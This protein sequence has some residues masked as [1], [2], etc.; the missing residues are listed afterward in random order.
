MDKS[1]K[2]KIKDQ[3]NDE[4]YLPDKHFIE[5]TRKV[6][7]NQIEL[8]KS[9]VKP[10]KNNIF[11]NKWDQL[12][13]FARS[14]SAVPMYFV[15]GILI[16]TFIA[17]AGFGGFIR[18]PGKDNNP[19][20]E[21]PK[22]EIGNYQIAALDFDKNGV[23]LDSDLLLKSDKEIDPQVLAQSIKISPELKFEVVKENSSDYKIKFN[24]EKKPNTLYKLEIS[25]YKSEDN[26][27]QT[28]SFSWA[29]QTVNQFRVTNSLPGKNASNV[30]VNTGI[31][32]VL[33]YDTSLLSTKKVTDYFEIS[34]K[35]NGEIKLQGKRI[36]FAPKETLK[37]STK[38]SVILKK[39]LS[40]GGV[41]PELSTLKENYVVTF[42]TQS[43]QT[44]SGKNLFQ[45]YF[46]E[47][48]PNDSLILE[49]RDFDP[50]S[51]IDVYK[52]NSSSY[53]EQLFQENNNIDYVPYRY[54]NQAN[55]DKSKL[56]KVSSTS[57]SQESIITPDFGDSGYITFN[58]IKEAGLYAIVLP[59]SN[60]YALVQITNLSA[61]IS[62]AEN[63]TL[64]WVNDVSNGQ[65]VNG[66]IVSYLG[67]ANSGTTNTQ[68]ITEFATPANVKQETYVKP[69]ALKISANNQVLYLSA[70]Q[71]PSKASITYLYGYTPSYV[72]Y[73]NDGS[74][75]YST[76]SDFYTTNYWGYF[77][78]NKDYYYS[79]DTIKVWGYLKRRDSKPLENPKLTLT[80]GYQSGLIR[81]TKL[82]ILSDNTFTAEIPIAGLNGQEYGILLNL[83]DGDE[84]LNTDFV[85]ISDEQRKDANIT[86]K[87]DKDIYIDKETVNISGN[88]KL[89]SGD[90]LKNTE[91]TIT[92]EKNS[93]S[94]KEIFKVK[95]D[96]NGNF[97]YKYPLN[98]NLN[99]ITSRI[100][101]IELTDN[102]LVNSKSIE[103]YISPNKY[104]P[105]GDAKAENN[106]FKYTGTVFSIKSLV[107]GEKKPY[108]YSGSM[109]KDKPQAGVKV[110]LLVKGLKYTATEIRRDYDYITKTTYPVYDYKT[111]E[112]IVVNKEF[113]TNDK[114]Q[115]YYESLM[116]D[117]ISNYSFELTVKDSG[118]E[119]KSLIYVSN[120]R[121]QYEVNYN[122]YIE[123]RLVS[124]D[125]NK[126]EFSV[127]MVPGLIKSKVDGKNKTLFSFYNKGLL[128]YKITPE[129]KLNYTLSKENAPS[130]YVTGV[131]FTGNTYL[132]VNDN[133]GVNLMFDA[134][135]RELDIK[136][137]S[138]KNTYKPKEKVTLNIQVKDKTGKGVKTNVLTN[139]TDSAS[140]EYLSTNETIKNILYKPSP[141]GLI[142]TNSSHFLPSFT[143][144]GG[145]KGG[146]SNP[147]VNIR[148]DFIDTP[149]FKVV[150][151]DE[152]G[153]TKVEVTLP[154][155]LTEWTA[156][157]AAITNEQ[158][159]EY[160]IGFTRFTTNL[161]IQIRPILNKVYLTSDKSTVKLNVIGDKVL[162]SETTYTIIS[163][164][165]GINQTLI[166]TGSKPVSIQLAD[167]LK[168]GVH[169]IKLIVKNGENT[170]GIE[171]TIN[172]IQSRA[173]VPVSTTSNLE[174]NTKISNLETPSIQLIFSNSNKGVY[175]QT[176]KSTSFSS[177]VRLDTRLASLTSLELLN[178]YYKE[179]YN[180]DVISFAD[181]L[182]LNPSENLEPKG[183]VKLLPYSSADLELSAKISDMDSEYFGG[184][185]LTGYFYGILGSNKFSRFEQILALYGLA[186][187]N[188]TVLN[189]LN[190]YLGISDLSFEEK[191]YLGLAY[192]KLGDGQTANKILNEII[193]QYAENQGDFT[194]IKDND[195]TKT[196]TKTALVA[197]LSTLAGQ[198]KQAERMLGYLGQVYSNYETVALEM[199]LTVKDLL[200]TRTFEESEFT[201]SLNGEKKTVNL[202]SEDGYS[203]LLSKEDAEKMTFEKVKNVSMTKV[204]YKPQTSLLKPAQGYSI[205]R[206]VIN[207]SINTGDVYKVSL[208]L[209]IPKQNAVNSCTY[210]KE[211][212]PLGTSLS[213]SEFNNNV[214][215]FQSD[216]YTLNI[217]ALPGNYK[218]SYFLQAKLAGEYNS[219]G[220]AAFDSISGDLVSFGEGYK[221]EVK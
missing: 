57:I 200:K 165:L 199:V 197:R 82:N 72:R 130:A 157:V 108:D 30:P 174:N 127:E 36:I 23:S 167:K 182:D 39:G 206:S 80:L 28:G 37:A 83:I 150:E 1:I 195:L 18:N 128:E 221:I 183:G 45:R 123:S 112:T 149:N 168:I 180:K 158:A 78:K 70:T 155:N 105:Q 169:K 6:L 164:T 106:T 137:T 74:I 54:L 111:E 187:Q 104:Y 142:R 124:S 97:S 76:Y 17:Y 75:D 49:F 100:F 178:K 96:E 201:Y 194:K 102:K 71:S 175:Y 192:G 20:V 132:E 198:N 120:S 209:S 114:G 99:Y 84:T 67:S 154:D 11:Q 121:F 13:V 190:A 170:D 95:T 218:F 64:A 107:Q 46:Y 171:E 29:F 140:I 211:Y 26:T 21:I 185:N 146:T 33:N 207:P 24:E 27:K 89:L 101:N 77:L 93:S 68:G 19:I 109:I 136:V 196:Y 144:G 62:T 42:T 94:N 3:I 16:I 203:L 58:A 181:Y 191:V 50:N 126:S 38:Y 208:T 115:I 205:K 88:V 184:A 193:N 59:S 177:S 53:F 160:G 86:V 103:V 141:N 212:L 204:E 215:V 32:F 52:F 139:V 138:D 159:P 73:D 133:S 90:N 152:S 179:S 60:D 147:D 118:R 14:K 85:L 166:S 110:N 61:Y 213:S 22:L 162:D 129:H 116:K 220:L 189:E 122:P 35:I 66:A 55:L 135:K 113:T 219:E 81:E 125:E 65:A 173:T 69:N 186:S 92:T 87:T 217:C 12:L 214:W 7:M 117:D 98:Q 91:L 4:R 2:Q 34:P 134:S 188:Q 145:G 210:I 143:I 43:N 10:V 161:P 156:I 15:L 47:S 153:N 202:E 151:T 56:T 8:L 5:N 31:E 163:E 51:I 216:P 172:V 63:K 48:K 25:G 40:I 148:T 119:S 41:N 131:Y 44:S 9:N 176:L 79:T